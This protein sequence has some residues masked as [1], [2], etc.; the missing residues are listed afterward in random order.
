MSIKINLIKRSYSDESYEEI[1]TN[2][3]IRRNSTIEQVITNYPTFS[4]S[5]DNIYYVTRN[6]SSII[7]PGTNVYLNKIL[8]PGDCLFVYKR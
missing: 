1:L 8:Q 4:L 6:Q 5:T 7:V 2:V 3:D